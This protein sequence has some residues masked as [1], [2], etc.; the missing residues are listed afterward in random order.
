MNIIV[1][2]AGAGS[3]FATAGFTRPKPFIDVAGQ[4]MIERVLRNLTISGA[5]FILLI[6]HEHVVQ[7]KEALVSLAERFGPI[8]VPVDRLTEGSA[9]TVLFAAKHI[10][11]DEPLLIANSDQLVDI[12]IAD[13]IRDS[14]QRGLDGSIMTFYSDHP[15]WSYAQ[16]DERGLV[17]E[18]KEKQVISNHATVGIYYFARGREYVHAAAEM[19]AR[20]DRSNNEFYNAPVYNYLIRD[21]SKIGIYEIQESQ[22]HGLGTPE[23]L[24]VYLSA[25]PHASV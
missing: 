4:P 10:N 2:M 6:R 13:Y 5:R 16:V 9:C 11:N 24:E 3:R 1:P 25:Q 19:I 23:D 8:I 20:S 17:L 15:K 18:T 14:D 7:E 21:G 12:A 22:M